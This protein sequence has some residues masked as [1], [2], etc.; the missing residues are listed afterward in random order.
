MIH[1]IATIELRP[2]TRDAFLDEFQKI[3]PLVHAEEGCVEYVPVVDI[4][5]GIS[6]AAPPR[7]NVVTIVE[8]WRAC[9]S[10]RRTSRPSTWPATESA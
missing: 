4:E 2:G 8:K 10:S 9:P 3:V 7:A 5:T 6:R 1:V